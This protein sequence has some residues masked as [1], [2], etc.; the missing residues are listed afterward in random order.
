[1][2]TPIG[3]MASNIDSIER[4]ESRSGHQHFFLTLPALKERIASQNSGIIKQPLLWML[5]NM[6]MRR[7]RGSGAD[8]LW[9][10]EKPAPLSRGI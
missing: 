4:S 2:D 1:V 8:L 3:S 9:L 6:T 10:S 5:I 7:A